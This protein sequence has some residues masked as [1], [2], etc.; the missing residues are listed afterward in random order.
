VLATALGP[1]G[2]RPINAAMLGAGAFATAFF[3]LR[4]TG[5]PWLPGAVGVIAGVLGMVFGAIADAW[6][7]AAL[8]AGLFAAATGAG[9]AALKRTWPPVAAVAG[10]IGL[11]VGITRQRKLEI[12]LPPIFA[13]IF[14]ALGAAIGWGPHRRGAALWRLT[15]VDWVLGLA[16]VLALPLLAVA[17]YRERLRK[18]R[19]EGRTLEMDDDDLKKKIA[20]RQEEYERAAQD[21]PFKEP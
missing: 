2:H 3:G 14:A 7:T 17:L 13:A 21:A 6:G 12:V 8:M 1:R 9:V 15:D 19:L 11:F 16:A 20:A 4:G 5:H 10:S 18:A